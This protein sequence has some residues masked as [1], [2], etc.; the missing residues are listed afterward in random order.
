MAQHGSALKTQSSVKQA[1]H[2]R[3]NIARFHLYEAPR[4]QSSEMGSKTVAARG[5]R[6]AELGDHYLMG[7]EFQSEKVKSSGD[8]GG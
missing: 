5:W 6:G 2:E 8:G 7:T 1:R 3:T 4:R